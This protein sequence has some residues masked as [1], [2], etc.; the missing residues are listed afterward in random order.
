MKPQQVK[1]D[2]TYIATDFW[3]CVIIPWIGIHD[4]GEPNSTLSPE[5]KPGS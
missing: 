4:P 1:T 5:V 3:C 2:I